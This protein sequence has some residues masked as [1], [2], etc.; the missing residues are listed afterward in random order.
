MADAGLPGQDLAPVLNCR[1]AVDGSA[2]I[3]RHMARGAAWMVSMRL[4][5]RGAGLINMA[6]L[7]R[8]LVPEDFGLIAMASLFIGLIETFSEFNFDVALFRDQKAERAQYDTAWTL[9]IIRG[10]AAAMI[11]VA[12][13]GPAAAAFD[14]PR[15]ETIIIVL[16]ASTLLLG[17]QNIG[18]VDFRKTLNFRKDFVFL[19]SEKLVAVVVSIALAF[20]FRNY[21]A[22][23]GGIVVSKIW[24]LGASYGMHPY[25]PRLSLAEWRELFAFTKWLLLQ[26]MLFFLK[27][28]ID[29]IVIGKVLGATTLGLYTI[30]F[31]F[32]NLVTSELM[33]PI[34]RALLPGFARLAAERERTRA[35][36][37]EVFGLTLWLG[38]PI[39]IGIGLLA[40]PLVRVLLGE[41]WLEAVPLIQ[42][43][44]IS[45]FITLLSSCS[46]PIFLALN[47]PELPTVL[48]ALSLVLLFPGLLVGTSHHGVLGAAV[49]VMVAQISVAIAD[50]L[51]MMRLLQLGPAAIGAVAWRSIAASSLM[52]AAVHALMRIWPY[53]GFW[54]ADLGLLVT[55]AVLGG[56]VYLSASLLL[57]TLFADGR[58]PERHLVHQIRHR[59]LCRTP[60][61]AKPGL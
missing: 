16:A 44:I 6:V 57:W 56:L 58:G 24:R 42:V 13:A 43:L 21:W 61:A 26:N 28:R 59:L 8:L 4:V 12:I 14:E 38:A 11:L 25:R 52:A 55:A 36:F 20:L 5:M 30:A 45:G 49:A 60:T 41:G 19:A 39:A 2:N 35:M 7:A 37:L 48:S 50:S 9:S 54:L 27:T 29:R 53:H 31:D 51:V 1:D 40:L 10:L 18:V 46:H 23:V 15:L 34:R 47:R 22:L 32:A 17:F 3:G 33:A